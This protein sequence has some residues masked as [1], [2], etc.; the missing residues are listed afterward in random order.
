MICTVRSYR[1]LIIHINSS[2]RHG[3]IEKKLNDYEKHHAPSGN[4]HH[5]IVI[6]YQT[7]LLC[8]KIDNH[9]F[10]MLPDQM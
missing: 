10:Q 7:I 5:L 3:A 4:H 6:F 8:K 1:Q 9:F 2:I